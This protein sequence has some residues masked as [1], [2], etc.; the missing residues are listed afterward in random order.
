MKWPR[1]KGTDAV[2]SFPTLLATPLLLPFA[3]SV[4]PSYSH[5][6]SHSLTSPFLSL[7]SSFVQLYRSVICLHCIHSF[8][9]LQTPFFAAG[10]SLSR[11]LSFCFLSTTFGLSSVRRESSPPSS[12]LHPPSEQRANRTW[13]PPDPFAT[14]SS[15][16]SSP[17][18]RVSPFAV[19]PLAPP[20]PKSSRY[21]TAIH[22]PVLHA[23]ASRVCSCTIPLQDRS[24]PSSN[25][26]LVNLG[27][28]QAVVI[29]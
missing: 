27:G 12:I 16:H 14:Q 9:D 21:R 22:R 18:E 17:T 24:T 1:Q 23:R 25:L 3:N 2:G 28:E 10:R 29:C 20:Q 6:H 26:H 11:L 13:P 7:S 19:C 4:L 15:R 5:S 8:T